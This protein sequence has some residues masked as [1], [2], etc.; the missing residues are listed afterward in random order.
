MEPQVPSKEWI[1][2]IG[3]NNI[4]QEV[5][6]KWTYDISQPTITYLKLT[7]ETLEQDVKYVLS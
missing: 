3:Q 2:I 5:E 7:T 1:N 4:S 6:K